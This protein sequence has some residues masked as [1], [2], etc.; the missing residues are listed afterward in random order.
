MWRVT[1]FIWSTRDS[2]QARRLAKLD[3]VQNRLFHAA[4]DSDIDEI[5]GLLNEVE[6]AG[7]PKK[8]F[9]QGVILSFAAFMITFTLLF[10]LLAFSLTSNG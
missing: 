6:M 1:G 5:R 4:K 2:D 8:T 3:E 7:Q 10:A 9:S